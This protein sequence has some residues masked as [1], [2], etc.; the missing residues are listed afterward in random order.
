MQKWPWWTRS[1]AHIDSFGAALLDSVIGN[2][3]CGIV[4]GI[5]YCW[6]LRVLK[7][8]KSCY[9]GGSLFAIEE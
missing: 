2:A 5:N 8:E 3:C 6:W 1:E 4:V 7:Y 9:D